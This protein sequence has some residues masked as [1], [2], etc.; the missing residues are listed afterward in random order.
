MTTTFRDP[1]RPISP[2]ILGRLELV[3]DHITPLKGG[4][5][6][7]VNNTVDP[8]LTKL[9]SP[10]GDEVSYYEHIATVRDK[11]TNKFYVAFRETADALF[12]RSQDMEKFPEWIMK[13]MEKQKERMIFVYQVYKHPKDVSIL[14]SHEDWLRPIASEDPMLWDTVVYFLSRHGVITAD[15]MKGL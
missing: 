13:S 7:R 8:R 11:G 9:Q 3:S 5:G 2:E 4:T 6:R 15:Q 14:R 10:T 12:A 1:V